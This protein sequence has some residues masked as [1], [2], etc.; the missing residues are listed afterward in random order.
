MLLFDVAFHTVTVIVTALHIWTEVFPNLM[1]SIH[2]D[3]IKISFD[4][5]LKEYYK[6]INQGLGAGHDYNRGCLRH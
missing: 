5:M 6:L 1:N 3:E 2:A 4:A